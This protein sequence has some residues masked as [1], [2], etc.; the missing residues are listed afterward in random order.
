MIIIFGDVR[1]FFVAFFFFPFFSFACLSS[2]NL[3]NLRLRL[4][5]ASA[6][7]D[8]REYL[9]LR[10]IGC[11]GFILSAVFE[12]GRSDGQLQFHVGRLRFLLWKLQFP[13]PLWFIVYVQLIYIDESM[14]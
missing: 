5:Y 13:P 1:I 10:I 12:I 7:F 8:G 2:Q 6:V 14:K 9:G 3:R 11:S 4:R